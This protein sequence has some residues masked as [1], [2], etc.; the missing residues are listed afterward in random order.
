MEK[1]FWEKVLFCHN[2]IYFFYIEMREQKSWHR[3]IESAPADI[4]LI[5]FQTKVILLNMDIIRLNKQDP[6]FFSFFSK[7]IIKNYRF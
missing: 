4:V 1:V 7:K 3:D 5:R 6:K 2:K